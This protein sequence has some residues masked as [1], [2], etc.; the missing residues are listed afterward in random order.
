[1][2]LVIFLLLAFALV[3][4]AML[5]RYICLSTRKLEDPPKSANYDMMIRTYEAALA[6]ST[7]DPSAETVANSIKDQIMDS[8]DAWH[9]ERYL[10]NRRRKLNKRRN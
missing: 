1:M 8:D 4:L 6:E 10:H 3:L 7:Y 5:V 2:K 9:F